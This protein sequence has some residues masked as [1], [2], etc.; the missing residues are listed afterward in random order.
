M[1]KG[2]KMKSLT[3]VS[4]DR[5][6]LLADISY[7]LGKENINIDALS[8][9]VVGKKA[10]IA[11]SVKNYQRALDVLQ[12]N[13]YK[14]TETDAIVVKLSNMPGGIN[15]IAEIL[16]DE[17]IN[18]ENMYML[19]SDNNESVF[20][21]IVDKPRKASRVLHDFLLHRKDDL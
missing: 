10:L 9:E 1:I 5:S 2:D 17:N 13:G 3:I 19:S 16:L 12:K 15:K 4:D 7:I 14:S 18:I 20:A 11:L 6:G 21:L 8:V